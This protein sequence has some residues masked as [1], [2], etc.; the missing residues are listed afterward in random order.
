MIALEVHEVYP[1]INI[2][3]NNIFTVQLF[4]LDGEVVFD[5]I[6]VGRTREEARTK[7]KDLVTTEMNKY[8][9]GE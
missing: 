4:K 6:G 9:K 8:L 5:E 7:A 3:V 2:D 1:Q